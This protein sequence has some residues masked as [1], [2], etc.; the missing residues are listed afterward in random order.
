MSQKDYIKLLG[1]DGDARAYFSKATN[2]A[3][4]VDKVCSEIV[5]QLAKGQTYFAVDGDF[6][7]IMLEIMVNTKI[8]GFTAWRQD[9]GSWQVSMAM[10][11]NTTFRVVT[12]DDLHDAFLT[13]KEQAKL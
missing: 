5:E 8:K 2:G 7:I 6:E 10:G 3:A 11:N 9:D 1:P 13:A 12:K 4:W